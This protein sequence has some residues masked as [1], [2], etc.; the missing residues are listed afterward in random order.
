M[1]LAVLLLQ[2]AAPAALAPAAEQE[3]VVIGR[4]LEKDW[5][6]SLKKTKGRLV[7]RTLKSTGDKAIDAIGCGAMLTCTHKIEPQMDA[8]A[9][10]RLE[11]AERRRRMDAVVQT[12]VPCITDY[13]ASAIAR[14]AAA[15]ARR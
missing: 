13:R 5:R 6:G 8:L 3:I 14:L 2:A 9:T 1:I 7:C 4:K 10:G 15:R 11:P 12:T